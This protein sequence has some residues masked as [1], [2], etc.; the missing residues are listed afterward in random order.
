MSTRHGTFAYEDAPTPKTRLGISA[1]VGHSRSSVSTTCVAPLRPVPLSQTSAASRNHVRRRERRDGGVRRRDRR[2][3]V[4][5]ALGRRRRGGRAAPRR[6]RLGARAALAHVRGA[7]PRRS[8]RRWRR[9]PAGYDGDRRWRPAHRH[10]RG[11]R[12]GRLAAASA[13]PYARPAA[14]G[15]RGGHHVARAVPHVQWPALV[16]LCGQA[17]GNPVEAAHWTVSRLD[18]VAAW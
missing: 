7:G 15:A 4:L 16:V 6:R 5:H 1:C 14:F 2:H 12:R 17:R 8:C 11:C 10:R 3:G 13:R 18:A 9:Q